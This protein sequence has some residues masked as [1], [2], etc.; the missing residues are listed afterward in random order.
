MKLTSAIFAAAMAAQAH[1]QTTIAPT[2]FCSTDIEGWKAAGVSDLTD[3][4]NAANAAI[5]AVCAGNTP[6]LCSPL[7]SSVFCQSKVD[8]AHCTGCQMFASYQFSSAAPPASCN[9]DLQ[10]LAVN[11]IEQGNVQTSLNTANGTIT[12]RISADVF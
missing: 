10:F 7:G 3:I 4:T 8:I 6:S 5:A 2:F 11:C 12:Y 1:S 9:N